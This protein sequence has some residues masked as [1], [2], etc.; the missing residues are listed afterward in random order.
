MQ[1]IAINHFDTTFCVCVC[2]RTSSTT[3][4]FR[5]CKN[6][7]FLKEK[8]KQKHVLFLQ[9]RFVWNILRSQTARTQG[10][11][12]CVWTDLDLHLPQCVKT[13]DVRPPLSKDITVSL[14]RKIEW[15]SLNSYGFDESLVPKNHFTVDLCK[16]MFKEEL[17]LC[18][19][20]L[21][22]PFVSLETRLSKSLWSSQ[23]RFKWTLIAHVILGSKTT[24]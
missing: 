1:L 13:L 4:I 12:W 16:G 7:C 11:K 15:S 2:V 18:S 3:H 9:G 10:T 23:Q 24:R 14:H 17:F 21:F 6:S 19:S 8:N 20:V 22:T 5:K